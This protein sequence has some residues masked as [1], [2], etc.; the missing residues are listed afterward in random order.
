MITKSTSFKQFDLMK[1]HSRA[2]HHVLA[3]P[4]VFSV[5][6][7]SLAGRTDG[8]TDEPLT[9]ADGQTAVTATES[10]KESADSSSSFFCRY[11]ADDT[12]SRSQCR[13]MG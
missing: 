1:R 11:D 4:V 7:V 6:F 8:R 5:R 13:N 2:G 9:A 12:E 3:H 10:R